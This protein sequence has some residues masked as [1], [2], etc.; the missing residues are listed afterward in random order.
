MDFFPK[1]LKFKKINENELPLDKVFYVYGDNLLEAMQI[2]RW[3]AKYN[4]DKMK[5]YRIE[6]ISLSRFVYEYRI[7]GD[8]YY[9]IAKSYF[10]DGLLPNDVLQVITN[11]DKPDAV[12]YSPSKK[13]VL[14][15]FES[16][17]T[18]LA[19]NATWQRAGR[20]IDFL[21]KNI[22]FAFLG[23]ASKLDQSQAGP[24][25]KP[26]RPSNIFV[27]F[28]LLL[29]LKYSTPALIGFYEHED[30]RQ[31]SGYSLNYIEAVF[32]YAFAHIFEYDNEE[33]MLT[34]CFRNMCSYYSTVVSKEFS[35]KI[36]DKLLD[37]NTP[38]KIVH[39]IKNKINEKFFD[40]SD[41]RL[42][43]WKP[44]SISGLKDVIFSDLRIYQLSKNCIAGFCF[45]TRK[46]I[47]TI[48][49]KNN[50]LSAP[51]FHNLDEPTIIIP[52][53]LTKKQRNKLV[54]TDDPYNGAISAFSEIY[55]QSFPKANVMLLLTDHNLANNYDVL[56]SKNHKIYKSITRYADILLDLDLQIFDK[57]S[58][59]TYKVSPSRF[60]HLKVTEDNV[61]CFFDSI[62]SSFG[63]VPS[64]LNPPCG[65]WS[66]LVLFPTSKFYYFK[67]ND[68]RADIAYYLPKKY[69]IGE[70]KDSF[71]N[72][73]HSISNEYNKVISI[74]NII[75]NE[76]SDSSIDYNT[77]CIFYGAKEEARAALSYASFDYAIIL[78]DDD[79]YIYLKVVD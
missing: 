76:I 23:Y 68:I 35:K 52:I 50:V 51:Y 36:M 44:K 7:N 78:N 63:I 48:D 4:S 19:G 5:F 56:Q 72:L 31:N 58:S 27:L 60:T 70:A 34:D 24:G 18:T 61:V 15:G 43:D 53:C 65:S 75:E 49:S 2:I 40:E 10:R 64:F 59:Y 26:R 41:I 25:V 17:S 21:E 42:Y 47:D 16:T 33:D 71:S 69:H 28:Y 13:R 32:K 37:P 46:L 38:R 11:I 8:I 66:D 39:D 54:R 55:K 12:I 30:P 67:R 57:Y 9:F 29:S 3:L 62:L 77:F 1:D 22:P 74:K 45:D 14:F 73:L 79:E 20:T 6:Y